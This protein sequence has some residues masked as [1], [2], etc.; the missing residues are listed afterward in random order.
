MP[1][2]SP[3]GPPLGG[4][5]LAGKRKRMTRVQCH[6]ACLPLIFCRLRHLERIT[7]DADGGIRVVWAE[8]DTCYRG[9]AFRERSRDG[10]WL[11]I[12]GPYR[13]VWKQSFWGYSS[14]S[15]L[16]CANDSQD[17][18]RVV[19]QGVSVLGYGELVEGTWSQPQIVSESIHNGGP[20]AIAGSPDG[21]VLY[22][23]ASQDNGDVF[24]VEFKLE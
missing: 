8:D 12:Q 10:T 1:L 20:S 7:K 22:T 2:E 11:P 4:R 14:A 24:C 5:I 23:W 16:G 3:M 15:N 9:L 21:R 17:R 18:L 6:G 19:W 13:G